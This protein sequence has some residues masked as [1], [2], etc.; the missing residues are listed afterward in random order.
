MSFDGSEQMKKEFRLPL[1]AGTTCGEEMLRRSFKKKQIFGAKVDKT[2]P[3]SPAV[4]AQ[5]ALA[6]S[7]LASTTAADSPSKGS[8]EGP[9]LTGRVLRFFGYTL[10]TVQE[11]NV[12]KERVRKITLCYFLEDGT[13][14]VSEP[15][16]DN[17][18]FAFQ[19]TLLKRHAIP[20]AEGR[21]ITFDALAVGSSISFYGR[22]F[23]LTDADK[24]TRDFYASVGVTVPDAID[25][26]NDAYTTLR[27]RPP[28]FKAYECPSIASTSALNIT[29]SRD[30]INATKQFLAKDRQVL[31]CECTWNDQKNLYGETHYLTLYYFLSDDTIA[32]AEKDTPNCGRDP[33]PN[34]VRRQRIPRPADAAT[35]RF[36]NHNSSLTFQGKDK[37][38]GQFYTSDDIRIGNVLFVFGRA[39]RIC[40]YDEFTR[41]L[42]KNSAGIT[43]YNPIDI[44][45][46][47][48]PKIVRE[49]PPYNGFG[50]ELDS[51]GSC[52]R[53]DIK[54]PRKDGSRFAKHGNNVVKFAMKL[55]N[56]VAADEIRRFVLS[57]FLADDT[58]CIFE[59]VQRNSGIVGGKFLQRQKVT[60]PKTGKPFVSSDFHVGLHV[61]INSFPFICTATDERSLN[62]MEG[63]SETFPHSNIANVI[64]KVKAMLLSGSSGLAEAMYQ[65]DRSTIPVDFSHLAAVA[66]QLNLN[67]SEQ[68]ILT[69]L[70]FFV[71]QGENY[72]TYE[73]LIARILPEGSIVGRDAASWEVLFKQMTN[74]DLQSFNITSV[75][76]ELD[77]QKLDAAAAR[78]AGQFLALYAQRPAL[79]NQEFKFAVDY[80]ADA[81]IG[82]R[83]FK[84][85]AFERLHL[86]LD[87]NDCNALCAKLFPATAARI[88]FEDLHRLFNGTSN[89]KFNMIQIKNGVA[90]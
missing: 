44:S 86:P 52:M 27:S 23:V 63:N 35:G 42:L 79:F 49:P 3:T 83:E 7:T 64:H 69:I 47:P 5:F 26:P 20:D 81:K 14:S 89:Q 37:T 39:V 68:E 61:V 15:R 11:S 31:R 2:G 43:E 12:E 78:C 80:A 72:A 6:N 51:L 22:Q 90:K 46:P 70:R 13:I 8:G 1:V 33:F 88:T 62:Y 84:L 76:S 71:R 25:L 28:G 53:L 77:R 4:P 82:E 55:E 9:E 41:E 56:G 30:Q 58:I 29:L 48:K 19:G 57:C 34:F 60:N 45:V 66:H 32:L 85:A 87:R 38:C 10:E 65:L 74:A 36:E 75:N 17:S 18:G 50:D 73:E 16:M 40:S 21:P 54:A 67:L 24:F 59:P